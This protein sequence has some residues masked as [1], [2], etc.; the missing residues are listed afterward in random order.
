MGAGASVPA[1]D[2]SLSDKGKAAL[3][4]HLKVGSLSAASRVGRLDC[5]LLCWVL[6]ILR[7]GYLFTLHVSL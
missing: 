7:D 4:T 6:T 1:V 3:F 2:E 5:S